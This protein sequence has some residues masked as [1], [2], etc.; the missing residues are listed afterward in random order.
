MLRI[1]TPSKETT[2]MVRGIFNKENA[3]VLWSLIL[4]LYIGSQV[5]DKEYKDLEKSKQE[6]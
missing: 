1:F 5:V 2:D 4:A 6:R 3:T